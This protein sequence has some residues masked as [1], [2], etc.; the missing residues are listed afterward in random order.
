MANGSQVKAFFGQAG[1]KWRHPKQ[2]LRLFLAIV[3]RWW[4]VPL[5][6]A[7]P[8]KK[9]AARMLGL[10]R[11]VMF[12]GSRCSFIAIRFIVHMCAVL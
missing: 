9:L 11:V 8:N 1:W 10:L 5:Y 12:E 6:I 3:N 4:G 2:W 7:F